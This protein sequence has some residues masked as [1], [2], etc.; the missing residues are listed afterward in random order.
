MLKHSGGP[1]PVRR[2]PKVE[3]L[4]EWDFQYRSEAWIDGKK[5]E[6]IESTV[7]SVGFRD[8]EKQSRLYGAEPVYLTRYDKTTK[9]WQAIAVFIRG[10][11]KSLKRYPYPA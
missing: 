10:R 3:P 8:S 6:E 2:L 5:V 9:T 1:P 4:K 11:E 7:L